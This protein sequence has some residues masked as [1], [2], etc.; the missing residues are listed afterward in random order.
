MTHERQ[1]ACSAASVA[2][3]LSSC[4]KATRSSSRNTTWPCKWPA[5]SRTCKRGT[6]LFFSEW[7]QFALN[8]FGNTAGWITGVNTG[9]VGGGYQLATTQLFP[10][11]SRQ[12][13]GMDPMELSRVRSQYASVELGRRSRAKPRCTHQIR[14]HPQQR[15]RMSK[16]RSAIS[17]TTPFWGFRPQHGSLRTQQDQRRKRAHTP[18]R[19]GS[20]IASLLEENSLLPS[21]SAR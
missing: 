10:Y 19:S 15:P 11:N 5:T 4:R 6:A 13:S 7:P 9:N 20:N 8:T 17:R 12:Y 1:N 3:V 16:R 2:A 18:I 21:S 14:Y